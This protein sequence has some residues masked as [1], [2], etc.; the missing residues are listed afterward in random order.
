MASSK[1]QIVIVGGGIMG[2]CTAYYLTHEE[3]YRN[4]EI[5]VMLVEEG[6]IAGG[7]SGKG[8]LQA[9]SGLEC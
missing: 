6:E 9:T 5:D 4:G 8:R 1:T 2:V 3:A 7:A